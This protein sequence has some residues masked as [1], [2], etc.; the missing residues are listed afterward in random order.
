MEQG[1]LYER[2]VA[3]RLDNIFLQPHP[4]ILTPSGRNRD[5][6]RFVGSDGPLGERARKLIG[7]RYVSEKRGI[8]AK[9][10]RLHDLMDVTI[11]TG[12][13]DVHELY[14]QWRDENRKDFNEN[15]SG[16]AAS[17]ALFDNSGSTPTSLAT[18]QNLDGQTA[19]GAYS[20]RYHVQ[21]RSR[22]S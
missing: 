16:A 18:V 9:S 8:S 11:N 1:F 4:P 20:D 6:E 3:S 21:Y 15:S 7:H 2:I 17:S 22:V 5:W 14:L 13:R 12:S 10:H 19:E